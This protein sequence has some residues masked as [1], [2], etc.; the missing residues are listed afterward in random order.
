M[1]GVVDSNNQQWE[2]CC[3]CGKY[4]KYEHLVY[5]TLAPHLIPK[6]PEFGHHKKLDLCTTCAAQDTQTQ[7]R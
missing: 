5:A 3:Q 1:A 4:V 2:H 7:P 6:W